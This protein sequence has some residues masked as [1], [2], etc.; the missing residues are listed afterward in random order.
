MRLAGAVIHG[1][2]ALHG[3]MSDPEHRSLVGGSGMTV[4][5]DVFLDG[6]R[7]SGGMVNFRNARLGS[8]SAKGAQL[9]N[10]GGYSI[11]LSQADIKGSVLLVDGFTSTGLTAVNRSTI[12]GRLQ[13]T[14]GSFTC[15]TPVPD[16]EQGHAIEMISA[17]VRGGMDLGWAKVAPSVDFTGTVTT[18]LGW[19]LS[20]IFVLSLTRLS[21]SP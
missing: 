13:L 4:D 3:R 2:L 15:A 8:L 5:G 16:N 1:T 18:M 11:R 19:L 6:L 20:S 17:I 12:E 7:T 10:P 9:H 14:G 21:R